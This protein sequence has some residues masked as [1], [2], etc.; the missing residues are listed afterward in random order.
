M[1]QLYDGELNFTG[2]TT[3]KMTYDENN[4]LLT[5]NGKK[6]QYDKDGNM[7]Y[8]PLNGK[9]TEFVFDCRN[10]LIKAGDTSYEYDMRRI[11]GLQS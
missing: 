2:V 10:R 3:A 8:G 6:V 9:M 11:T 1:K 7:T 4:R 5:Y